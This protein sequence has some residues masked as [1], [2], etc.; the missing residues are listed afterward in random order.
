MK[1]TSHAIVGFQP[2]SARPAKEKKSSAPQEMSANP[3]TPQHRTIPARP[4]SA[5]AKNCVPDDM[6]TNRPSHQDIARWREQLI[7][8]ITV[9]PPVINRNTKSPAILA[10]VGPTGVGKTT[11]AAKLAAWYTLREG[12]KVTLASIDCYRI[13]ATDQ[14]RTYA[15]IMRLPCEIVLRK[16]EF[17]KA[18]ERHSDQDVIIVDTAG[19]SPY[20]KR[21]VPELGDWFAAVATISPHLVISATSKKEDLACIFETYRPLEPAGV[22][23]AKIDET[24][25]YATLCQQL[26][27]TPLPVACLCMGQRVP[28][29]FQMASKEFLKTLF[30]EGLQAASAQAGAA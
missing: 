30:H 22:M 2:V 10:L 16:N 12:L 6:Q 19:K 29:D 13:G 21:H 24:R 23:V 7:E 27:A 20:D 1:E 3:S 4:D 18:L 25:A 15:R 17:M 5:F 11:T 28:E 26:A 9:R 8:Q 14:L